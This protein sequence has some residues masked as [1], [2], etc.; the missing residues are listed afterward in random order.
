[1]ALTCKKGMDCYFSYIPE[2]KFPKWYSAVIFD[3]WNG[4]G[5]RIVP[6][7]QDGHIRTVQAWCVRHS[8]PIP[9]HA[10]FSATSPVHGME[11]LKL[12]PIDDTKNVPWFLGYVSRDVIKSQEYFSPWIIFRGRYLNVY[13]GDR[14]KTVPRNFFRLPDVIKLLQ[15]NSYKIPD[16]LLPFA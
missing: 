14:D 6:T 3:A 1:M 5:V 8:E 9:P 2:S 4:I 10:P 11:L 13:V 15:E 7:N 16:Q 12:E